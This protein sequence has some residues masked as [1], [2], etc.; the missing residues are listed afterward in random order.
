MA[1]MSS[2]KQSHRVGWSSLAAKM[3]FFKDAH[4]N[5]SVARCHFCAH[6]R[7]LNLM[8]E[9]VFEFERIHG[10]G[11]LH[12]LQYGWKRNGEMACVA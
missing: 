7:A 2:M 3:F 11:H 4:E 8:V 12:Q 5:V 10:E 6:S 9:D 1:K